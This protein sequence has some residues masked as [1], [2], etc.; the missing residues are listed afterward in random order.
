MC[1][2]Q[3]TADK[4]YTDTN[5]EKFILFGSVDLTVLEVCVSRVFHRKECHGSENVFFFAVCSVELVTCYTN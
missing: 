1:S 3:Y 5:T 2:F 4:K